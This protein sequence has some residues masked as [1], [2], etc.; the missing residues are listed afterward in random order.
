MYRIFFNNRCLTVCTIDDPLCQD[1]CVYVYHPKTEEIWEELPV[2]FECMLHVQHL[3]VP[4]D[5]PQECF[6]KICGAFEIL[7]AAGGL[8]T[9]AQGD[10]LMIYRFDLWDLPKGKQEEGE[11]IRTTA[12]REVEE[13][14]GVEGLQI[15]HPDPVLTYHCYYYEGNLMLK[16]TYWFEMTTLSEKTLIPQT[17]EGIEKVEWV[18]A[19][20]ITDRLARTYASL[21]QL[22]QGFAHAAAGEGC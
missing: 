14:T 12:L 11:D 10:L 3:V 15:T 22:L 4:V 6:L 2:T 21:R 20:Q 13:E 9:N 8:V 19:A 16:R 18:P 17:E 7:S 1:P 5:H